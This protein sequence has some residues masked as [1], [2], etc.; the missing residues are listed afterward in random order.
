MNKKA[1]ALAN[2]S[3]K[4]VETPVLKTSL[5]KVFVLYKMKKTPLH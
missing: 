2:R 5:R 1:K 4:K 3:K